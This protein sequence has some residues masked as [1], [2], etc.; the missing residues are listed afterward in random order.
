M[1]TSTRLQMR[2][3]RDAKKKDPPKVTYLLIS[4]VERRRHLVDSKL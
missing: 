3:L 1:D 4:K 2:K